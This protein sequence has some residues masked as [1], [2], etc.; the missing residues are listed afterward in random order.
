MT[1]DKIGVRILS[2]RYLS[3]LS[4]ELCAALGLKRAQRC[5]GLLSTD[6]DDA[7]FIALDEASKRANVEVCYA[8]S[9]YAGAKNAT[10]ALAGEVIGV[11]GGETP[12]EVQSGMEGALEL[13]RGGVS[14]RT[15]NDQGDIVYLSHCVCSCGSYLARLAQIDEGSALAYLIAPPVEAIRALDT[16]L[17]AASVRLARF[18]APPTETNFCGGLLTG[19]QSACRAACDAFEKAVWDTAQHPIERGGIYGS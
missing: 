11:L 1:G 13:L 10:T 7:T 9:L 16:A 4:G 15:A 14:F 2:V 19:T 5:V 18:F 3:G 8:R 17:K 6:S 12:A